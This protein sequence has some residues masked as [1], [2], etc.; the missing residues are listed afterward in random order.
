MRIPYGTRPWARGVTL[1]PYPE[2]RREFCF[3][4]GHEH[5]GEDDELIN[6]AEYGRSD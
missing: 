2:S 4:L 5:P 6:T 1:T 3:P